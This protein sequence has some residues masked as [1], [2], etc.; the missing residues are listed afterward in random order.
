MISSMNEHFTDKRFRINI[1]EGLLT[2]AG[3]GLALGSFKTDDPLVLIPML[4]LSGFAFVAL[5][6]LHQGKAHY[7]IEMALFITV[8]LVFIGWRDLKTPTRTIPESV[9][10]GSTFPIQQEV[11]QPPPAPKQQPLLHIP[12]VTTQP[13]VS[14][15]EIKSSTIEILDLNSTSSFIIIN[16]SSKPVFAIG[17]KAAIKSTTSPGEESVSYPLN[18]ELEPHKPYTFKTDLA[19]TFETLAPQG[20]DWADHWRIAEKSY[21]ACIR[22][23][24]FSPSSMALGQVTDH[25]QAAGTPLPIGEAQGVIRYK[26]DL[27]QVIK[28]VRVP[29]KAI[30]YKQ[31][32]CQSTQP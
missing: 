12:K 24:F 31:Q 21:K 26:D 15:R 32:G 2:L 19:G 27:S 9:E 29:L 5:C 11:T 23:A 6:V 30:L 17:F 3:T 1:K 20:N 4:A 28:E 13:D 18:S 25:Y 7:R 8:V 22:I 14:L 16:N 10:K